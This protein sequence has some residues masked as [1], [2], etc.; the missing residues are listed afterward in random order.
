MDESGVTTD[1][2]R[3]Y[4]RSAHGA[5]VADYARCGHWETHTI[6]AALRPTELT[7]TAV[8]DGPIDNITFRAYVEQVL[9]PTI[10]QGCARDSQLA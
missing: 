8:F 1:L 4:A 9:I 3:R 2:L 10:Q 5:R 6:V 7:A